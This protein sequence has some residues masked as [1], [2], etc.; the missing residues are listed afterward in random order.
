LL[1]CGLWQVDPHPRGSK[2]TM[3]F[4]YRATAS[5]HGGFAIAL[6]LVFAWALRCIVDG[7]QRE[8]V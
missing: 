3:R 6:R 2:V 1:A 4:A 8:A 5:V 7:W